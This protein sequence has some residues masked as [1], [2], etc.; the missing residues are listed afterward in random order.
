MKIAIDARMIGWTGPGTYTK[1]LLEFLQHIDQTNDYTVLL[2]K[3]NWESWEPK[4]PNFKKLLADFEPY[5][6][7]EQIGLAYLLYRLKPNLVHFLMPNIPIFYFGRHITTVHDL[8]LIDYN[9][10]RR[11]KWVYAVKRRVFRLVMWVAVRFSAH[12][13]TPTKFVKRQIVERYRTDESKITVTYEA[14]DTMNT[15]PESIE[16][17]SLP[18]EFILSVGNFYPYKN[19]GLVIDALVKLKANGRRV[20]F[21]A[22]G[23]TDY[24]TELLKRKAE[25]LG[26]EDQVVF[27]GYATT[28][29]LVS[30]YEKASLYVFPSLSEGFGLPGLAAMAQ[31]VPVLAAKASCLPEVYG[32]AAMYFDPNDATSLASA[33]TALLD[34]PA[35][36]LQLKQAG[37]RQAE[38]YSWLKMASETLAVYEKL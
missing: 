33:I 7:S 18:K 16:R 2:L 23:K 10:S 21:V 29:Q 5:S 22:V 36:L 34:A 28:G 15:K 26:V 37:S 11:V 32:D 13:I 4:S 38:K 3:R 35:K 14:V 30:L 20:N 17:Y 19:L 24:F 1:R 12:L 8:T 31:G 25:T 6:A 9:T 27:T